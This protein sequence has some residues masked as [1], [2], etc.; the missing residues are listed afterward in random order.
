MFQS[1]RVGGTG[2]DTL[3]VGYFQGQAFDTA[4]AKVLKQV[5][6]SGAAAGALKRPESTGDAGAIAEAFASA[7]GGQTTRVLVV[8]LGKPEA[9]DTDAVRTLAG[10]IGRKLAAVKATG[11]QLALTPCFEKAG[12]DL[13]DAGQAFGEGLGLLAWVCDEF[14][15]TAAKKT[16]RVRLSIRA[17]E[18]E[19]DNA[20]AR[21]VD[22]AESANF[23]RT[24]SQTPPNVATTGFIA[25]MARKLARK[26]GLSCKILEGEELV[27]EKMIGLINVGK[28]RGRAR[29]TGLQGVACYRPSLSS[30]CRAALFAGLFASTCGPTHP[31]HPSWQSQEVSTARQ[32]STRSW[33][34]SNSFSAR[35]T[36]P[37]TLS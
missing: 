33:R 34:R 17:G 21:G 13:A 26:T 6:P 28:A 16:N 37:G 31:G 8:G 1:I 29:T 24:L 9:L 4:T 36:P 14:K 20:M 7:K 18:S 12:L 35:P 27:R 3:V 23:T 2:R 32:A 10:N 5:D 25:D 11:V 15:G 19:F 30:S 22:L